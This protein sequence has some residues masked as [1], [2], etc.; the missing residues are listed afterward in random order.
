MKSPNLTG[1]LHR[2]ALLLQEFD[3][4]V[5]FRP[6]ATN[7]VADALSRAQVKVLSATGRRRRRKQRRTVTTEIVSD[8]A[9]AP[10]N[11][12]ATQTNDV[13]IV[14]TVRPQ[15]ENPELMI[16]TSLS[17]GCLVN[18]ET[19]GRSDAS[20]RRTKVATS[21]STLVAGGSK[22]S[23]DYP[24]HTVQ[25]IW[26]SDGAD[27][28]VERRRVA[29]TNNGNNGEVS[30]ENHDNQKWKYTYHN[31]RPSSSDPHEAWRTQATPEGVASGAV[32][33]NETTSRGTRKD[34][35]PMTRSL[36]SAA[37]TNVTTDVQMVM[38]DAINDESRS[39]VMTSAVQ[40]APTMPLTRA[41]RRRA[42][43]AQ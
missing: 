24:R 43:Q 14:T 13:R 28:P 15:V 33:T 36:V 6:G 10:T 35:S 37:G 26:C 42:E 9:I 19:M 38:T 17:N 22:G 8:V 20:L 7:V 11:K 25:Q 3:F 27:P 21:G 16:A 5:E 23:C 2:W 39:G 30:S 41:A 32:A 34:A 29:N 31:R 4:D 12:P 18:S 40:E 1:K